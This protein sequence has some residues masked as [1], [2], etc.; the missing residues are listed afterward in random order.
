MAEGLLEALAGRVAGRRVL[1]ARAEEARDTLPGRAARGRR[2]DASTWCRCT[3]RSRRCRPGTD[4]LGRR[5]R[6]VHVVVDRAVLRDGVRRPRPRGRA[7]RLDRPGHVGDDARARH[8]DRRRGRARTTSTAWSRPCRRRSARRE[9]VPPAPGRHRERHRRRPWRHLMRPTYRLP[10]AVLG[11]AALIAGVLALKPS[12]NTPGAPAPAQAAPAATDPGALVPYLRF[13][14]YGSVT[15]EPDTAEIYVSTVATAATSA[16]ALDAASQEDGE[17]AG[18]AAAARRDR[19]RHDDQQL[20]DVPGL[21]LEEVARRAVV[22]REGARRS[23]TPASCSRR[24]TR[25]VPTAS[26]GRRSRS[27]TRA[28][29][30]RRRCARRSRMPA[31]RPRRPPRR[32]ASRSAAS[33]RSTTRRAP[34]RRRCS[35]REPQKAAARLGGAASARAGQPG[36]QEIVATVTVVFTYTA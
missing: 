28:P 21:R 24:P 13:S 27:T 15:V 18:A 26:A 3:A 29:R 8:P 4:A 20:L 32:W 31:R 14:G 36:T 35:R 34:A 5:P 17:G 1:V 23:T 25:P 2:R 16:A 11:G 6:H 19:G 22:E 7:G 10:L 9:P 12:A 33:C 30:T